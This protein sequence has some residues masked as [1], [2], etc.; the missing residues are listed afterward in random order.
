[1]EDRSVEKVLSLET[2]RETIY[3]PPRLFKPEVSP[4]SDND[5]LP[6][7]P[8]CSSEHVYPLPP[9]LVCPECAHE[10]SEEESGAAP[11]SGGGLSVFDANGNQLADG[12]DV[13]VI[14]TLKVKG[15]SSSVKIGTKV[16]NIRL[17]DGDHNIDCKVPGV[18]AMKLK[19]EFVKKA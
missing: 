10:W 4:L 6:P 13:T 8:K 18:G 12:D 15:S 16:R 1:M 7:C 5:K 14:K 11:T 17:T 19:S 2:A 9:L 3:N